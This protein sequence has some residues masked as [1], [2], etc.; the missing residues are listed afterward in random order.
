MRQTKIACE[1]QYF[2]FFS[3]LIVSHPL[4]D[5]GRSPGPK[6]L[7]AENLRIFQSYRHYHLIPTMSIFVS[8]IPVSYQKQPILTHPG[9]NKPNISCF[10]LPRGL[11]FLHRLAHGSLLKPMEGGRRWQTILDAHRCRT[12]GPKS[13]EDKALGQQL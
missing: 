1:T 5:R 7:L 8:L 2:H 6:R 11:F 10:P 13:C 3:A 9:K 4:K 12:A